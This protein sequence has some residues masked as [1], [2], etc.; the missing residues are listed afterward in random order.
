MLPLLFFAAVGPAA[1]ASAS[2]V[3]ASAGLAA[4][5]PL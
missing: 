4:A 5:G 2:L 1:E 3:P